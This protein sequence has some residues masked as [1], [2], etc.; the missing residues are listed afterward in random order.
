M[1]RGSQ[2]RMTD[3][4]MS[5]DEQIDLLLNYSTDATAQFVRLMEQTGCN[6]VSNAD[7]H[8]GPGMI[9]AEI[10]V[11][12]AMPSAGCAVPPNTSSENLRMM[13]ATTRNF[14]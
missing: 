12:Y 11:K 5:T 1:M 4:M 2:N 10:C 8:A 6:M 13:I 3:L 14:K 7:S 9:S